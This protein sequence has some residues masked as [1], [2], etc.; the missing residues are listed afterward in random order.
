MEPFRDLLKS[1]QG[2]EWNQELQNKFEAAK[3]EIV[4]QIQ[5]GVQTYVKGHPTALVT[6]WSKLVMF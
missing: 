1:K 6:D 2:F 5:Y 4:Q 3:S